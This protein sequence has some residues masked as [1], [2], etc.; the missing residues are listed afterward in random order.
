MGKKQHDEC[1]NFRRFWRTDHSLN[2][3]YRR[4]VVKIGSIHAA[5]AALCVVGG[6]GGNAHGRYSSSTSSGSHPASTQHS[7]WSCTAVTQ[8]RVH[9]Q[10][11]EGAFFKNQRNK[12]QDRTEALHQKKKTKTKI[13]RNPGR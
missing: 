11:T 5:R 1:V 12:T 4:G 8:S 2:C 6:S 9:Q 7:C 10:Q 13:S 3:I